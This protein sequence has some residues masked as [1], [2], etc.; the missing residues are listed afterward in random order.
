[1]NLDRLTIQVR[2]ARLKY[3]QQ[4][5]QAISEASVLLA[6]AMGI[7][8][9]EVITSAGKPTDEYLTPEQRVIEHI[10][11]VVEINQRNISLAA[12]RAIATK[13]AD[14]W[15]ANNKA[16]LVTQAERAGAEAVRIINGFVNTHQ[17]S[18]ITKDS[19]AAYSISRSIESVGAGGQSSVNTNGSASGAKPRTALDDEG[20]KEMILEEGNATAMYVWEH[21]SPKIPFPPHEEL[22]GVSWTAD[23]ELEVLA[24]P[25]D[26]PRPL[27][28]FPGDHDGC[29]CRYDVE[30]IRAS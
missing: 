8:N 11:N 5:R 17:I 4:L 3:E 10:K 24:N 21:G 16:R 25:N 14:A 27:T 7:T 19:R 20:F 1:M 18:K 29:T 26:I 23:D 13:K 22:D 6:E 9:D 12:A 28:Y 15:Y 30:F 2:T